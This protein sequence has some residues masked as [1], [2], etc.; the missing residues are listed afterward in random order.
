MN[1]PYKADDIVGARRAVPDGG[2]EKFQTQGG[3]GMKRLMMV[4]MLVCMVLGAGLTPAEATSSCS[5]SDSPVKCSEFK[6]RYA[7]TGESLINFSLAELAAKIS[8]ESY[9]KLSV[10]DSTAACT[11]TGASP[12]YFDCAYKSVG[13][14]N[15]KLLKATQTAMSAAEIVLT[16]QSSLDGSIG[17]AAMR[18]LARNSLQATVGYQWARVD[19]KLRR[20]VAVSFRGTEFGSLIES[21]DFKYDLAI[22]LAAGQMSYS[23]AD[24]NNKVHEGF[25]TSVKV[26]EEELEQTYQLND[27]FNSTLAD[28]I[29]NAST[30]DDMFLITGH[31]LGGAVATLY[32]ARL[33]DR[34]VKRDNLLL[35]T[36]GAPSVGN[37]NFRNVF[38]NEEA[39]P[40]PAQLAKKLNHHRVRDKYDLVPYL[41][42]FEFLTKYLSEDLFDYLKFKEKAA[43]AALEFSVRYMFSSWPYVHTGYPMVY[44]YG[45]NV[46]AEFDE[47]AI[48]L[49]DRFSLDIESHDM[50]HYIN[51]TQKVGVGTPLP[52]TS[53]PRITATPAQSTAYFDSVAVTLASNEPAKIYFNANGYDP[54]VRD[55][56]DGGDDNLIGTRLYS[57]PFSL[58]TST[59]FRAIAVDNVG[60]TSEPQT[61]SYDIRYLHANGPYLQI[62]VPNRTKAAF[63]AQDDSFYADPGDVIRL[64]VA[65]ASP[66]PI[67]ALAGQTIK[68]IVFMPDGSDKSVNGTLSGDEISFT[69]ATT[70]D[71][72]TM[73]AGRYR[74]FTFLGIDSNGDK[75]PVPPYTLVQLVE[76]DVSSSFDLN[77]TITNISFTSNNGN[78]INDTVVAKVGIYP[79]TSPLAFTATADLNQPFLNALDSTITLNYGSYYAIAFRSYGAHVGPGTVSFLLNGVTSFSQDVIFPDPSAAS[80]NFASFE[81][82]NGDRLT[83]SATGFSADRIKIGT[84]GDGLS[85]DGAPDAYYLFTFTKATPSSGLVAHWSFDDCTA[86]DVS[87][88]GHDGT[89]NGNPQCVDGVIGK[90]FY[91]NGTTDYIKTNLVQSSV[92]AYSISTWVKLDDNGV[93][94]SIMQDRGLVGS[95]GKSITLGVTPNVTGNT[96]YYNSIS[97]AVEADNTLIGQVSQ[98]ISLSNWH[99]IAGVWSTQYSNKVQAEDFSLYL[100]GVK[101]TYSTSNVLLSGE[102]T[103]P[104]SPLTGYGGTQI[105]HNDAWQSFLKGALDELKIYNRALSNDEIQSLYATSYAEL[106]KKLP[107]A[108]FLSENL[109]DNSYQVGA[110]T[111]SWRF[112]SGTSAITGL[113]AVQVSTDSGLGISQTEIVIGDVAANT[114][115]LVNLPINPVHDATDVKTSYWKLVDGSNQAVT[116]TNSSSGQ[117]WLKLKTNRPPVFSQLQ[118]ESVSGITGQPLCLPLLAT[119]PDNDS[120]T[121][122]VLS[123]GGSVTDGTCMGK[124]GKIYQNNSPTAGVTKVTLQISDPA[125]A[126]ATQEIYTVVINE[127]GAVKDFFNDLKYANASTEQL[128]EQYKAINYLALNGIVIGV[129]DPNDPNGRIFELNSVTKQAEA[130]GMIMKAAA[131]L[132]RLELDAEERNLPNLIKIDTTAMTYQNFSWAAPYVLKAEELGMIDSA[133]TFDPAAPV[134]RAWLAK[135]VYNLMELDPP[136]DALNPAVYLFSDAASFTSAEEYDAARAAAFFGYMGTLTSAFS[137]ADSMIRAD[138]A[139]VTARILQTP[140]LDGF[141]TVG[142]ADQTVFDRTLPATTHGNSFSVNAL[143]NLTGKTALMDSNGYVTEGTTVPAQTKL[144]VIRL[145][146]G[147]TAENIM[148]NTLAASP[149]AVATNPPDISSTEIRS[150]LLLIEDT[151]SGVRTTSRKEYG[152]IFPD[153][154]GDGVRDNLD[155]WATNPLFSTDANNN[156][157]PDNADALWGLSSRQGSEIIT[158]NGQQMT[159]IDAILNGLYDYPFVAVLDLPATSTTLAVAVNFFDA[160]GGTAPYSY[161]LATTN[162]SAACSWSSIKPTSYT[163]GSAGTQTLYAFV[164]DAAAKVSAARFATVAITLMQSLNVTITNSNGGGGAVTIPT[165]SGNTDCTS[166]TCSNSFAKDVSISLTATPNAASSFGGWS[167][168]CTNS[169]GGCTVVMSTDKNLGALFNLVPRARIGATSYGTLNSAYAVVA[170]GQVIEIKALTFVENLLLNRGLNITLRGGYAD[171]YSGQT[172]YTTLD[173]TLTISSGTIV[174]DRIVVK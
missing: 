53:I 162:S 20:I 128:K 15:I 18:K 148:A 149:V 165:T 77:N 146:Y 105:A 82:P 171:N 13:F 42:Y 127:N 17:T 75:H 60:N 85:Q 115:F 125:A 12:T 96:N 62:I 22:D 37:S 57:S 44:A 69:I 107:V 155:H 113:K 48:S 89:L 26:M 71:G 19:G 25:M 65:N 124:S 14:R 137:P 103:R 31:S 68:V 87:G 58:Q 67:A 30:S 174:L 43:L 164:K 74:V 116:I 34:G 63:N 169:T 73:P 109:P 38:F 172:G 119:D 134:T 156:G 9:N 66:S 88:N 95:G 170:G 29:S 173:G 159:L 72:T 158:I 8:K 154:D 122:S 121:Y 28:I 111:K 2:D 167:G 47:G 141:S 24:P 4:V 11:G 101:T 99:H 10:S 130:L 98:N 56:E 144:A 46:T 32:A 7:V 157:I 49:L 54:D 16:V 61:F 80:S 70:A 33:L 59:S 166:G 108:T 94:T 93:Y 114:E 123:G 76:K 138:V 133:D 126:T 112:K 3:T 160:A 129:V 132:G 78:F 50:K 40:A 136:T 142:L 168:A 100:D 152:V 150:L 90:A 140:A 45:Q 83:I 147:V 39:S 52:D 6:P 151:V 35:Y 153:A 102:S 91:F 23:V 27:A 145:G 110:A 163:F 41:A 21:P 36:F 117:F 135:M 51:N 86:K 143:T 92:A 84:D 118:L 106:L 120:I 131:R 1:C 161:C 97:Y 79:S 5:S 104:V 139:I 81:L 55:I 64:K